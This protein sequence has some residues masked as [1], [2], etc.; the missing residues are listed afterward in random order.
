MSVKA[1][2]PSFIIKYLLQKKNKYNKYFK[3]KLKNIKY[4]IFYNNLSKEYIKYIKSQKLTIS[5]N[6][7]D[8]TDNK[9]IKCDKLYT[10]KHKNG[11]AITGVVLEDYVLYVPVIFAYHKDY[12]YIY[13]N[14]SEKINVISHDTKKSLY[15]FLD[16]NF[17]LVWNEYDI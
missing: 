1:Y 11:W 9:K 16:N 17:P 14:F 3:N 6:P 5:F 2:K 10:K 4:N 8:I 13:G 12:G 15:H 7:W